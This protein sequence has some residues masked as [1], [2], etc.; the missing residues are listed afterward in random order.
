MRGLDIANF[1]LILA[2]RSW[3]ARE[4]FVEHHTLFSDLAPCAPL[5]QLASRFVYHAPRRG[6]H[7]RRKWPEVRLVVCHSGS[8]SLFIGSA[9][10]NV[11]VKVR[12]IGAAL[13]NS[14][15]FVHEAS[16]IAF[17]A[18]ISIGQ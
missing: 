2:T 5:D 12:A 1:S 15:Q 4:D 17:Q 11:L 16:N 7:V 9:A 13:I 18:I 14:M 3:R 8:Q 10:A 6:T